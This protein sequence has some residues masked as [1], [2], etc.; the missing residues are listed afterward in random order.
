MGP[1]VR[2]IFRDETTPGVKPAIKPG[3]RQCVV[4][5][6]GLTSSGAGACV[7]KIRGSS[8]GDSF[9]DTEI[10]TIELDLTNQESSDGFPILAPYA[11]LQVE[12]VSISGTDAAVSAD[13]TE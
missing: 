5:L 13:L 10:G 4:S 3:R 6:R 12:I 9:F 7:A 11:Y 2:P 8:T 1:T